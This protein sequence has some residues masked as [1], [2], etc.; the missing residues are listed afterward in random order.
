MNGFSDA[1]SGNFAPAQ[2]LTRSLQGAWRERAR[3]NDS[4]TGAS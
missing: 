4:T 3:V 2:I 1:R